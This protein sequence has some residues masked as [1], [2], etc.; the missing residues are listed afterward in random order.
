MPS[1]LDHLVVAASNLEQGVSYIHD[2]LGVDIPK[3]GEHPLMGTHNHVMRIGDEIF[4]EVIAVNPEAPPPSRPRWFGLDDPAMQYSLQQQPRLVTWAANTND[5][6]QLQADTPMALGEITPL[7]RGNLS[8][9]FAVPE[10]GRLLASGFIP[11]VMQWKTEAHPA[12]NMIDLNCRLLNL[13][14]YHPYA[15]WLSDILKAMQLD[16]QVSIEPLATEAKAYMSAEFETP[17]GVRV[18]DSRPA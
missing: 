9:L 11:N 16:N 3:G 13:T 2:V 15:P 14:I 12:N 1:K 5:L 10:D 17:N 8:W 4:L 7:S 18:L 6:E